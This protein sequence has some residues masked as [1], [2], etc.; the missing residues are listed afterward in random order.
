MNQAVQISSNDIE[1][2]LNLYGWG[3]W[4]IVNY[5]HLM[6]AKS[7]LG[8]LATEGYREEWKHYAAPITDA[9]AMEIDAAV[10]AQGFDI[11]KMFLMRYGRQMS[12]RAIARACRCHHT[13]VKNRLSCAIDD[14]YRIVTT[15]S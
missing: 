13:T 12:D 10:A 14:V 5:E 15:T 3:A 11:A 9:E 1:D 8:Q 6:G 4:A 2:T 7:I